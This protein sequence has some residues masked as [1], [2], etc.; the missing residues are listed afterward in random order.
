MK[1]K[2]AIIA[3]IA[4]VL[5]IGCNGNTNE[6][7][8]A[9][10]NDVKDIKELVHDYSVG[11][12]EDESASI[13]STQ[14]IVTD[15]KEKE[16]VYE[17]PEDEFFV[18]IAPFVNETHPCTNHSLTGCQ[19]EMINQDFDI[20]IEDTEGNIVLDETKQSLENGFI[21]LWLPRDKAFRVK[22]T[23]EGKEVESEISTFQDDG[24]C[25]TTMQ[26]S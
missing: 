4:S 15:D 24:T 14:L 19:G 11:N 22:I 21:D 5:L 3:L 8:T 16:T 25:I 10:D 20:Y 9:K 23:H 18:S 13:T 2:M 12:I 1:L 26:L 6:E 7:S 17:L